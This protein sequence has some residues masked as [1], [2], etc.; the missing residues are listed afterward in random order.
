MRA[1]SSPVSF[2]PIKLDDFVRQQV[3][4]KQWAIEGIW[5]EGASGVIAA[6]PK[7]G[8]STLTVELAVSLATATPMFGI[9]KFK[10]NSRGKVT[11]VHQGENSDERIR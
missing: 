7:N 6:P 3:S 11:Y 4:R 5:P 2:Q 10:S 9:D 8:K 1:N